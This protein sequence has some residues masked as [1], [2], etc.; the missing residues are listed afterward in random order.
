M[1]LES[2]VLDKNNGIDDSLEAVHVKL[3]WNLQGG[4]GIEARAVLLLL[5]MY[6]AEVWQATFQSIE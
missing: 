5:S 6:L 1:I 3:A 4:P 2:F